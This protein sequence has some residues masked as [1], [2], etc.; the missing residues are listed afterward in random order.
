MGY[1][2]KQRLYY[3]PCF[4]C[5]LAILWLHRLNLSI[6]VMGVSGGASELDVVFYDAGGFLGAVL[7]WQR[8]VE[9]C[10]ICKSL[11]NPISGFNR[12]L[13]IPLATFLQLTIQRSFSNTFLSNIVLAQALS[14][15]RYFFLLHLFTWDLQ[16]DPHV[17]NAGAGKRGY[18]AVTC[19]SSLAGSVCRMR[20]RAW[21]FF[22]VVLEDSHNVIVK[23][24]TGVILV[25]SNWYRAMEYH[26]SVFESS[27]ASWWWHCSGL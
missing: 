23:I 13:L 27:C 17:K 7:R 10:L 12:F 26:A 8:R 4:S 2:I 15:F 18:L 19:S 9:I 5:F 22:S 21:F 20:A 3:W 24:C 25:E 11:H 6:H 1:I 14:F 16:S